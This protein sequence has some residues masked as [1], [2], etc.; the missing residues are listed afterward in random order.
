MILGS[1]SQSEDKSQGISLQEPDDFQNHIMHN[2]NRNLKRNFK[3]LLFTRLRNRIEEVRGIQGELEAALQE[4]R[5]L[6]STCLQEI[7]REV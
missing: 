6:M 1:V 2:I 3:H 7:G 5:E 4:Q